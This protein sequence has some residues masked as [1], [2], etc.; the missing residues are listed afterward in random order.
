MNSD[1]VE[2]SYT[3]TASKMFST[4]WQNCLKIQNFVQF[5]KLFVENRMKNKPFDL[6]NQ[7]GSQNFLKQKNARS[8]RNFQDFDKKRSSFGIWSAFMTGQMKPEK[9]YTPLPFFTG[10][11]SRMTHEKVHLLVIISKIT[12][13]NSLIH[14]KKT[15]ESS[16]TNHR[17]CLNFIHF[18]ET[19]KQRKWKFWR[20]KLERGQI[21]AGKTIELWLEMDSS[22]LRLRQNFTYIRRLRQKD[23]QISTLFEQ[24]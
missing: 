4:Y 24:N 9:L 22:E 12:F 2:E 5:F 21:S 1:P 18:Q 10:T 6:G 15:R 3:I 13:L 16:R 11:N 7:G 14:A 17:Q 8:F 19:C 23:V 20:I